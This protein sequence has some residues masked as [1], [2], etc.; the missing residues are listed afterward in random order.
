MFSGTLK[1][2][3]AILFNSIVE[4]VLIPLTKI[5]SP[6]SILSRVNKDAVE[7]VFKSLISMLNTKVL[8]V[9][10]VTLDV[11]RLV[12]CISGCRAE[13]VSAVMFTVPR[14]IMNISAKINVFFIF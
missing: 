5:K 13:A 8:P 2:K 1:T 12:I 11:E 10:V 4:P 7:L 6:Q 14:V 9:C 3:V